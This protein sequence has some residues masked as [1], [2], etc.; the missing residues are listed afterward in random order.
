MW[1]GFDGEALPT[2]RMVASTACPGRPW[3]RGMVMVDV[4]AASERIIQAYNAKAFDELEI[5]IAPD[6][7][8][9]HFNRDFVMS[10]RDQLLGVL[11][12]FAANY[13]PDRLFEP[14]ER[15]TVAG[16]ICI[17]EAWYGGTAAVDLPGFGAKGEK[18]RFKFCSIMRFDDAGLLVEWKDHG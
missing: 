13:V 2:L 6:L 1:G 3:K 8:F 4:A 12:D 15:V 14:A 7:D 11:R 9:A 16:D 17:R 18:F 10:T 5:L